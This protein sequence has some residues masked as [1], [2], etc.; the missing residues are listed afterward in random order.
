MPKIS[1]NKMNKI[2]N[3]NDQNTPTSDIK[4]INQNIENIN[5][6][7]NENNH[8]LNSSQDIHSKNEA[9]EKR[10]KEAEKINELIQTLKNSNSDEQFV[11]ET[12][13]NLTSLCM[14][15]LHQMQE[16]MLLDPSG[17]MGECMAALSN[18]VVNALK[19]LNEIEHKKKKIDLEEEKLLLKKQNL[20]KN[21]APTTNNVVV[22]GSITEA[23]KL[24]KEQQSQEKEICLENNNENLDNNS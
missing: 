17:R 5:V 11:K 20:Q 10:K 24:I 13:K 22:I 23:L 16:E 4:S 3:L 9:Y 6:K 7:Q 21:I 1:K 12:L 15:S 14:I 19:E 2:F 8:S 18:S